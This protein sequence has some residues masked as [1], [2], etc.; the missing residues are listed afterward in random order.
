MRLRRGVM[1][2]S[3]LEVAGEANFRSRPDPSPDAR[4]KSARDSAA[5]TQ[6]A[7][8]RIAQVTTLRCGAGFRD[9]CFVKMS[10]DGKT[11]DGKP[12]VGWSEYLEERNV[13]VTQ[14][15]EWLGLLVVGEDPRPYAKLL[16][17]LKAHTRHIVGG[18]AQQGIAAI[19]NALLDVVGKALGV[20]VC[21]LMGGPLRTELPVYWSHCGSYMRRS[22]SR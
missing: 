20:L 14:V 12:I 10:T 13:G 22:R 5:P 15:I 6:M 4:Q 18:L 11:L 19:E 17:Q 1:A 21:A 16:A 9:F 8:L 3:C 7:V 2:I